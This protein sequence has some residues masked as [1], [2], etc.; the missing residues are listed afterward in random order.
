ML[1]LD[2]LCSHSP[3]V[4]LLPCTRTFVPQE[5][6]AE[7]SRARVHTEVQHTK[8]VGV[9]S[10]SQMQPVVESWPPQIQCCTVAQSEWGWS[11]QLPWTGVHGEAVMENPATRADLSQSCL[12][13]NQHACTPHKRGPG[14]P[15]LPICP[16]ILQPAKALASSA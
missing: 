1:A 10:S 3:C 14:F 7:A 11:I 6:S 2:W 16:V 5:Q 12:G 15:T 8:C 4:F 9:S 13:A